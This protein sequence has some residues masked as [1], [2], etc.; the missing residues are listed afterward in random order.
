MCSRG[1]VGPRGGGQVAAP[2]LSSFHGLPS[3]V[4]AGGLLC[5][6]VTG[7]PGHR[8]RGREYGSG[9]A[10]AAESGRLVGGFGAL[11]GFS[12]RC[13]AV[14]PARAAPT[15]RTGWVFWRNQRGRA[16]IPGRTDPH[17]RRAPGPHGVMAQPR[18][19]A[20]TCA[21]ADCRMLAASRNTSDE[22]TCRAASALAQARVDDAVHRVRG[23][24]GV[25]RPG[26]PGRRTARPAARRSHRPGGGPARRTP[27]DPGD[28]RHGHR[29]TG[30]RRHA[31]PPGTRP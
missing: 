3:R 10:D 11:Q 17:G 15:G 2:P 5:L 22:G 18:H 31:Q 26:L 29:R 16:H 12:H 4:R 25:T 27:G 23:A 24:G 13:V 19:S 20:G 28:R 6:L 1:P 21:G 8:R 14:P 9:E 7:T 30:P